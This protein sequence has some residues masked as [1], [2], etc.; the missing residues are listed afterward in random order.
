MVGYYE[1]VLEGEGIATIVR[2]KHLTASGL[3]EIP[4]PEFF[5]ALC[6][7]DEADYPRAMEIIRRRISDNAE[8][9]DI[10]VKCPACGEINPGNFDMCWSCGSE[11]PNGVLPDQE[12]AAE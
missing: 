12:T 5:P 9:A 1:S 8:N 10:E 7:V 3:S 11:M 2:N 6:V 4:I